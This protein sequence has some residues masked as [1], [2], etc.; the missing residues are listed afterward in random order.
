MD[1]CTLHLLKSVLSLPTTSFHEVAVSTFITH[2]AMGIGLEASADT[3]GNIWIDYG[4]K[5]KAP[6]YI[7]AHMDHPGFE[8]IEARGRLGKAVLYGGVK[9]ETFVKSDVIVHSEHEPIPAKIGSNV[10][11]DHY[12]NKPVFSIKAD[13]PIAIGDFGHF[14]L[15]DVK[16]SDTSIRTLAADNLVNVAALLELLTRLVEAK[17][18]SRIIALF[19]RAEEVGFIG[20]MSVIKNQLLDKTRPIIVLECSSKEGLPVKQGLGPII[21]S[22]DKQSSFV[23]EVE[24]WLI[25]VAKS[26]QNDDSNFQYQRALLM[27]GRCEGSIYTASGYLTGSIALALGNYHNHDPKGAPALEYIST[28][29]YEQH[30]QLLVKIAATSFK[31]SETFNSQTKTLWENYEQFSEKL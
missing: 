16:I 2:Y 21:R 28:V 30:I 27:G 1:D 20:A 18:K 13:A 3:A 8:I 22:G 24:A 6:I 9:H 26:L 15:P 10:L 17:S 5:N 14:N 19:T 29:D 7:T 12:F 31:N 25:D 11:P 4:P 23:P